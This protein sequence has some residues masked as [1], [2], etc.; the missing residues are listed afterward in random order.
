MCRQYMVYIAVNYVENNT[1][2]NCAHTV[3]KSPW[4]NKGYL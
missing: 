4:N 3:K 2:T 1:L